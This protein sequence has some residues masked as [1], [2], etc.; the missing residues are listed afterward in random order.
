MADAIRRLT[1]LTV[2]SAA[3]AS[4][5]VAATALIEEAADR[6]RPHVPDEPAARFHR[7]LPLHEA[8]PFDF[9]VG[10]CNPLAPPIEIE[11]DPP[12]ATGRGRFG[13]AYQGAPGWVHGAAIAAAFDIVLTAANQAAGAAGPTAWLKVRYR[14]PTLLANEAYFDAWVEEQRGN[15]VVAHGRL[16]QRGVVTAEAEGEFVAIDYEELQQRQG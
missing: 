8:M 14:R 9:V 10:R 5:L 15:R 12:K 2:S 4:E 6:L 1:G 11:L 16:L 7:D 3:D 13:I